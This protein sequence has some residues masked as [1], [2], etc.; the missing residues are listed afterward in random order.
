MVRRLAF[1]RALRYNRRVAVFLTKGG[2]RNPGFDPVVERERATYVGPRTLLRR[3]V[4][5]TTYMK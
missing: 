3:R 2:A 4:A 1:R 5:I